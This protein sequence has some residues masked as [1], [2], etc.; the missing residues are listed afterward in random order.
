MAGFG[1]MDTMNKMFRNNRALLKKI[2]PFQNQKHYQKNSFLK[3][4]T[5]YKFK[6]VT[7]EVLQKIRI[8]LKEENKDRRIT[9]TISL[10]ISIL[11]TAGMFWWLKE[12]LWPAI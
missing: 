12:Y 7:P 10:V 6:K 2:K 4:R 9:I 8:K 11:I 5:I 3:K 1:S